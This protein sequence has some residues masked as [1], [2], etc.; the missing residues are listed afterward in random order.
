MHFIFSKASREE[1]KPLSTLQTPPPSQSVPT[2]NIT[3]CVPTCAGVLAFSQP[4]SSKE[5]S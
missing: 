3:M 5:L 2:A 1:P 4:F